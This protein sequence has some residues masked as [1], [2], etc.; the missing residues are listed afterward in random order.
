MVLGIVN[1]P[2]LGRLGDREPEVYGRVRLSD[3]VD[4]ARDWGA[5]RGIAIDAFQANAEGQIID[6]FEAGVGRLSGAVLNPGALAHYGWA[7]RDCIAAL[8]YPV[9]EVH[10]T[11]VFGREPFRS[12][13]VLAPVVMGQIVGLGVQGYRLALMALADRDRPWPARERQD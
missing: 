3:I 9:V 10:L 7:L 11:N 1:G 4:A 8:D 2:N 5:E 12:R 6:F 13:L